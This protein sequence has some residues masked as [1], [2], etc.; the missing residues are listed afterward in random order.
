MV[1]AA[2]GALAGFFVDAAISTGGAGGI[3]VAAAGG[4]IAGFA[5]DIANQLIVDERSL[6]EVD[7]DQAITVGVVTAITNVLGFG[8]SYAASGLGNAV[9]KSLNLVQQLFASLSP[10]VTPLGSWI[11]QAVLGFGIASFSSLLGFIK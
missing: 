1:G 4:F 11:G 7:L 10:S 6:N 8:I 5:G 9:P 3:V 2:T